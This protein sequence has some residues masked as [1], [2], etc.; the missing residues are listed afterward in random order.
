MKARYAEREK[1]IAA[2]NER[3]RHSIDDQDEMFDVSVWLVCSF[4]AR[5]HLI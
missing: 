5:H 2:E 3:C 4:P 1:W